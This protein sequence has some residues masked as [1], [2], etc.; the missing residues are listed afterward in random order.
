M[1]SPLEPGGA[2]TRCR[3]PTPRGALGAPVPRERT[4]G[5]EGTPH[6]LPAGLR[7]DEPRRLPGTAS[8]TG[9]GLMRRGK[10]QSWGR[11]RHSHRPAI[12]PAPPPPAPATVS[13]SGGRWGPSPGAGQ[14]CS[15]ARMCPSARAMPSMMP[16]PSRN[17]TFCRRKWPQV[18]SPGSSAPRST[19][20]SWGR[21]GWG[22]QRGQ[23]E[24]P[25]PTAAHPSRPLTMLAKAT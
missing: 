5:G 9:G 15:H 8:A 7:R 2:S 24:T 21:A 19:S 3:P 13:R 12:L 4:R 1:T 17:P 16:L 25:S 6:P 23:G 18:P 20:G 14:G 22:A 10:V 11:I